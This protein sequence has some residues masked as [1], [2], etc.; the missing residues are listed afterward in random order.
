[1]AV[2]TSPYTGGTI[3]RV[4]I[5]TAI[6]APIIIGYI[7]LWNQRTSPVSDELGVSLLITGIVLLFFFMI[8]YV[9]LI[10]NKSDMQRKIAEDNLE[11][12]NIDLEQKIIERTKQVY[13]NERRYRS[14]IENSAEGISLLDE[15]L[16]TTY[17]SPAALAISG[18]T[19]EE[20]SQMQGQD[21][22]HPE[23]QAEAARSFTMLLKF[24]DKP[25]SFQYRGRHK[26]GEYVWI[27][28]IATN[29]LNDKDVGSI[30]INYRDVTARKKSEQEIE[31]N[32]KRLQAIL[33]SSADAI[34][35]TDETLSA[36]YQSPSA[37]RMTGISL[38]FRL[39][40]PAY[41]TLILMT[42]LC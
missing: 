42:C 28:G 7:E 24:P 12:L 27:E 38:A 2:I 22:I 26:N 20:R 15:N 36:K 29:L 4:L 33:E 14:L 5:P 8:L 40:T 9:A 3:A 1:M 16:K 39:A 25:Q 31:A 23:D 37:E 41:G 21:L 30:V 18:Y 6:L 32:E 13:G 19:L 11:Q 35:I 17:Q 34:V 10:I